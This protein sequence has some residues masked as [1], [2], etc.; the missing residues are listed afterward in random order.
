MEKNKRLLTSHQVTKKRQ[1]IKNSFIFLGFFTKNK[2][3]EQFVWTSILRDWLMPN[4][5]CITHPNGIGKSLW[6]VSPFVGIM[7]S[8]PVSDLDGLGGTTFVCC[9]T[10]VC[11]ESNSNF[12][13]ANKKS[14]F[15]S[16]LHA[17][18]IAWMENGEGQNI[19]FSCST[20]LHLVC[21][22]AHFDI[23]SS[24]KE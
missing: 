22:F 17:I 19:C 16:T 23:F 12:S 7:L 20:D 13:I 14:I 21:L 18:L 15:E 9:F 5:A 11:I 4:H 8:Q 2:W 6:F 10:T 3:K 1:K 24:I